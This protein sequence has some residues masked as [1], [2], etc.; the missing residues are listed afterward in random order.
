MIIFKLIHLDIGWLKYIFVSQFL[1]P[2]RIFYEFKILYTLHIFPQ[3]PLFCLIVYFISIAISSYYLLYLGN[4]Q[5][6]NFT[7]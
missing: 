7:F 2:E 6:L 1:Q 5:S 3:E 4:I